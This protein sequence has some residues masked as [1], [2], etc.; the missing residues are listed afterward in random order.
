MAAEAASGRKVEAAI[1]RLL[2]TKTN[3]M[4]DFAGEIEGPP[5]EIHEGRFSRTT[6]ETSLAALGQVGGQISPSEVAFS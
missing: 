1:V 2:P 3:S 5:R 4:A 6:L